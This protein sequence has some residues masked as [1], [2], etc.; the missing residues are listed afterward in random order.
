M[1]I[2]NHFVNLFYVIGVGVIVQS[3]IIFYTKSNSIQKIIAGI[4][5]TIILIEFIKHMMF[6]HQNMMKGFWL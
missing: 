6:I 4:L 3:I 1:P 5:S 2:L